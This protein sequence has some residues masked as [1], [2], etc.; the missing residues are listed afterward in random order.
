MM[1][2]EAYS[3]ILDSVSIVIQG[4]VLWVLWPYLRKQRVSGIRAGQE[5]AANQA[6]LNNFLDKARTDPDVRES[7]KEI[8][9]LRDL[10]D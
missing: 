1:S 4:I 2:V 9:G 5:R 7:L 6:R 8:E 10:I 3:A